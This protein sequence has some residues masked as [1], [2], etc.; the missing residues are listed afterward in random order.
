MHAVADVH[1]KQ[2]PEQAAQSA[3][4]RKYPPAHSEQSVAEVQAAQLAL[5]AVQALLSTKNPSL[6]AVHSVSEQV[7]QLA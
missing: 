3:P 6:Q 5:H 2:P 1:S 4:L 7:T